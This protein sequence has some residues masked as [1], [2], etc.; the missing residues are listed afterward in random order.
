MP[1]EHLISMPAKLY[2][3]IEEQSM[4]LHEP[5]ILRSGHWISKLCQCCKH[6][7]S[8]ND[9]ACIGTD[10]IIL[11]ECIGDPLKTWGQHSSE[12]HSA[13]VQTVLQVQTLEAAQRQR[14]QMT[15]PLG[16]ICQELRNSFTTSQNI[17]TLHHFIT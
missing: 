7:N 3:L 8:S 12:T 15:K 2:K 14:Y 9:Q 10:L 5:N 11:H 17:T 16:C 6:D 1:D 4:L 13:C